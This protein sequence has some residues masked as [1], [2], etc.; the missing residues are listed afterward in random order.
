MFIKNPERTQDVFL[1]VIPRLL[2]KGNDSSAS[3]IKVESGD[4]VWH[5]SE[6]QK[7]HGH[8]HFSATLSFGQHAEKEKQETHTKDLPSMQLSKVNLEGNY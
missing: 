4:T 2:I 1:M 3:I 6:I 5:M 7:L 8:H